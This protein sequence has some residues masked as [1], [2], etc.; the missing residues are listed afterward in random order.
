VADVSKGQPE[1]L[2]TIEEKL[3]RE[4]SLPRFSL[5]MNAILRRA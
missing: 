4:E 2:L 1:R 3:D 5:P